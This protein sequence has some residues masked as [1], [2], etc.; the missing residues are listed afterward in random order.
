MTPLQSLLQTEKSTDELSA[1]GFAFQVTD[2]R[3]IYSE[4]IYKLFLDAFAKSGLTG[5][6]L[7]FAADVLGVSVHPVYLVQMIPVTRETE[8]EVRGPSFDEFKT[9]RDL[10]DQLSA[11]DPGIRF[12]KKFSEV[13]YAMDSFSTSIL[14]GCIDLE[15]GS[16][17]RLKRTSSVEKSLFE[18]ACLARYPGAK[19]D[20][21]DEEEE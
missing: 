17:T 12:L 6:V 10:I 8:D 11:A 16:V 7:F 13:G 5:Q 9:F 3:A 20:P 18:Q 4:P 19:E 14:R 1:W 15:S 2:G 21:A